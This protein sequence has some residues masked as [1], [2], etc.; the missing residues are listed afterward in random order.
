M[1]LHKLRRSVL[2]IIAVDAVAVDVVS[3]DVVSVDV[4]ML[5][6]V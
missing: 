2:T 5:Y 6:L 1:H 3:V 4:A